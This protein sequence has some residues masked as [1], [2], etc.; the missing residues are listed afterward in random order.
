MNTLPIKSGNFHLQSQ[1]FEQIYTPCNMDE[2]DTISYFVIN[3]GKVN[4]FAKFVAFL[5]PNTYALK[6]LY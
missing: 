4:F 6:F 3:D 2:S 5:L 1:Y